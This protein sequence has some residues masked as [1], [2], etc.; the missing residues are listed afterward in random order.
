MASGDLV[1]W[2]TV[3]T[4]LNFDEEN[5][6]V[7]EF[8]ISASSEHAEKLAGRMLSARDVSI[9]LDSSGGKEILLPSYPVNSVNRI[10]IDCERVFPAEKDLSPGAYSVKSGIIRL[11]KNYFPKEYDCVLFEGNIGYDPVPGDLQQAIVECVSTNWRRFSTVGGNVGIKQISADG[12]ITTQY[13]IDI[14]IT[15]RSIFE[16]YRDPRI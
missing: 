16:K 14:P 13:E 5:K 11:Y 8:L 15:S 7:V 6:A 1:T 2:E 10:C 4:L 12:A 3:K 9:M